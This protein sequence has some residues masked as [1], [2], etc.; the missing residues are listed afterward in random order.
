MKY[1][2]VVIIPSYHRFRNNR[3][4]ILT[5]H[6]GFYMQTLNLNSLN[7]LQL[8]IISLHLLALGPWDPA[9]D[10]DWLMT[11]LWIFP[12]FPKYSCL[13]ST[14][15]SANLTG[16]PTTN[17]K[18]RCT[19]RTLARCFLFSLSFALRC[20]SRWR[21]SAFNLATWKISPKVMCYRKKKKRTLY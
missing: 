1:F 10:V 19:T 12:N 2:Q 8:I 14:S 21:F 4:V 7:R 11:T 6:E 17:T 9:Y 3:L 16:R 15:G 5:N 13:L 20:W 18:L